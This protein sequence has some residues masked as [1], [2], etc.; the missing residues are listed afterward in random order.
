MNLHLIS[1]LNMIDWVVFHKDNLLVLFPLSAFL[2]RSS[3]RSV[4][5]K[6]NGLIPGMLTHDRGVE[7]RVLSPRLAALQR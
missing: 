5:H 3:P 1:K 4:R 6:G 2:N 7:F